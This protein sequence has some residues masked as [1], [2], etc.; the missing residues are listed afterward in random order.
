LHHLF[1]LSALELN[2][3]SGTVDIQPGSI[4]RNSMKKF[5]TVAL[6]A[7]LALLW[8]SGAAARTE[9]MEMVPGPPPNPPS[10]P[11]TEPANPPTRDN[12]GLALQGHFG[13]VGGSYLLGGAVVSPWI[14]R[15]FRVSVAMG[16]AFYP[17]ALES[18]PEAQW[19]PFGY[20]QA[21][22]EVGPSFLRFAPIRP[23]AFGGLVMS[24]QGES[25]SDDGVDI[26]GVGG[27][28]LEVG[29]TGHDGRLGPVTY[30]FEFAG[31]GSGAQVSTPERD[32]NLLSGFSA[33]AV[34]RAY[35][36]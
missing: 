36:W 33:T 19:T 35:L 18:D 15:T 27:I 5:K 31:V 25:M 9:A 2:R 13:V 14:V 34:I 26:G 4:K 12:Q 3:A 24:I 8:T 16:A 6:I 28:G 23:Y 11:D 32:E 7:A 17:G 10:R 21:R 29:F 20:G 30:G 22:L 1:A